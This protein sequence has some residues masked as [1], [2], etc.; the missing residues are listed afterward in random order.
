MSFL[1][2]IGKILGREYLSDLPSAIATA[3]QCQAVLQLAQANYSLEEINQ[4][5]SYILRQPC[6]FTQIPPALEALAQHFC[7]P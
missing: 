4:G 1:D 7:R 3:E 6:Q 2:A 5:A